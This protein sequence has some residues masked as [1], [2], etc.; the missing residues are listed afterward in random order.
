MHRSA[1]QEQQ[2]AGPAQQDFPCGDFL[3]RQVRRCHKKVSDGGQ[4]GQIVPK[5][6]VK[7]TS[8]AAEVSGPKGPCSLHHTPAQS[9]LQEEPD[10][11]SC[12]RDTLP[13]LLQQMLQAALLTEG[14]PCLDGDIPET[15]ET[16][17]PAGG[18]SQEARDGKIM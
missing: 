14:K 1:L 8:P 9:F 15:C 3:G 4:A 2:R 16:L 5:L 17:L 12:P 11:L 6:F 13:E 7:R 10:T 18:H